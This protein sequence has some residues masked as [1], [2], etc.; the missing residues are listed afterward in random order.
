[1]AYGP[2]VSTIFSDPRGTDA[3][4]PDLSARPAAREAFLRA[5]GLAKAVR[6]PLAGDAST[7][8]YA[9]LHPAAGGQPLVLMDA[10]PVAESAPAPADATANERIALGYNAVA[11][12]AAGRVDAWAAIAAFLRARGLSAPNIIALDI[13]D[14]FAVLEDLGSDLL[15]DRLDAGVDAIEV[16][17]QAVDLLVALHA[18]PAPAALPI[19]GGG[20]WALPT[21]DA[22][23]LQ[24][25]VDL[26][27]QW[28][29]RFA[30]MAPFPADALTAWPALWSPVL[31]RGEAGAC[32]FTHRDYHAENLLWLPQRTGAARV[33]LLDFQDAVR[34]HPAWDLVSL[35]QD[36]RRD[37]PQAVETAMVARYL[38]ARPELDAET[39]RTDYARLGALNALRILG[40]IF[41][42]QIVAFGR[43]RY[44]AFLPRMWRQLERNLA[45][46]GL[47]ELKAWFDRYA[48]TQVRA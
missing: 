14:G 5:H 33:G 15:R 17:G 41:A 8:A 48:P 39:F 46:P 44:Q 20:E 11:R 1:M 30:G 16:Y 7:R 12:L 4:P 22:L 34:G 18:E 10:P 19:P 23:A 6:E 47:A 43:D 42:R 24:I 3:A 36:A 29:P 27:L 31:A 9:R 25:G 2:D 45:H 38:A 26:W 28:W 37:V 13:E 21:Y 35:L 32:V 40:P